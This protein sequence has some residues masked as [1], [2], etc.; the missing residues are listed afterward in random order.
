MRITD[1]PSLTGSVAYDQVER[2]E[3]STET[4]RMSIG[5]V[6]EKASDGVFCMHMGPFSSWGVLSA[7]NILLIVYKQ[8]GSNA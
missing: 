6:H 5:H 7:D 1:D 8:L 4:V 2:C 3:F